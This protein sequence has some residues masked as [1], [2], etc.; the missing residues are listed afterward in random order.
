MTSTNLTRF[1]AA[2][3]LNIFVAPTAHSLVVR[4]QEIK[5]PP[6]RMPQPVRPKIWPKQL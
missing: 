1:A 4:L 6:P 2:V 3:V 5:P